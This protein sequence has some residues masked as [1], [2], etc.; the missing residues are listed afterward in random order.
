MR[1]NIIKPQIQ[2]VVLLQRKV[3]H[4]DG[5]G[6]EEDVIADFLPEK[7]YFIYVGNEYVTIMSR[8]MRTR[9]K[10]IIS[11]NALCGVISLFL[12]LTCGVLSLAF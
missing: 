4:D 9:T 6:D 3:T 1:G 2:V 7:I 12:V 11:N 5:D 8:V 10:R